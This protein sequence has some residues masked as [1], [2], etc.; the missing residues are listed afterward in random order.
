MLAVDDRL[1]AKVCFSVNHEINLLIQRVIWLLFTQEAVDAPACDNAVTLRVYVDINNIRF[2]NIYAAVL[3][4]KGN[5][6]VFDEA[7]IKKGA[8]AGGRDAF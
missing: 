4:S 3:F 5:E 8:D 6:E 1:V 7:P 2:T